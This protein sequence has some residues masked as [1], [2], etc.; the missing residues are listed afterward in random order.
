M[1]V[2]QLEV[3]LSIDI[4]VTLTLWEALRCARALT[5]APVPSGP[6]GQFAA[7]QSLCRACLRDKGRCGDGGLSSQGRA[8]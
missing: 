2:E 5:P 4:V 3:A 6:L 1:E 7:L 8:L